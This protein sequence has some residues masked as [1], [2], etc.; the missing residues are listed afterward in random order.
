MMNKDRLL[1]QLIKLSGITEKQLEY[2]L[3]DILAENRE[4]LLDKISRTSNKNISKSSYVIT[5]RRGRKNI[6]R[7]LYT[8][9]IAYYLGLITRDSFAD[10][11]KATLILN[12]AKTKELSAEQVS[13]IILTL[14]RLTD[15]MTR[16]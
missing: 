11:E 7:A 4:R 2:L 14:E 13:A 1:G 5:C 12:E 10:L 6:K 8:L 16:A 9:I 15:K 3:A